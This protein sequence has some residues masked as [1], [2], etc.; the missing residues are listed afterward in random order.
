MGPQK[1]Q[2][3]R[4][5]RS[6]VRRQDRQQN[7]TTEKESKIMQRAECKSE[8][9]SVISNSKQQTRVQDNIPDQRE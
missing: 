1:I 7:K 4:K 6:D 5:K 9:I 2:E 8:R 3:T